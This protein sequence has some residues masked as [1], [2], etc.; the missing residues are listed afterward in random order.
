[1]FPQLIAGPIVRFRE[2]SAQLAERSHTAEKFS[3]GIFLLSLGLAKKVLL[4]NTI[5]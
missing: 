1:M 2:V 3:R 5:V 4:A